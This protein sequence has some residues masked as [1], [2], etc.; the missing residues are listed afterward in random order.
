MRNVN[1]ATADPPNGRSWSRFRLEC[2]PPTTGS[3]GRLHVLV[4]ARLSVQAAVLSS[5]VAILS[6]IASRR[7]HSQGAQIRLAPPLDRSPV[8][9]RSS[10]DKANF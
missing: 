3:S 10:L 2:I 6:D 9:C 5:V 4:E 8:G 7:T 1:S